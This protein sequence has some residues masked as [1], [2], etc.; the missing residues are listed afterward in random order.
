MDDVRRLQWG[1]WRA[2]NRL[3][4]IWSTEGVDRTLIVSRF[5]FCKTGWEVLLVKSFILNIVFLVDP[6]GPCEVNAEVSIIEASIQDPSE[7]RRAT[8]LYMRPSPS[9]SP[10]PR[11]SFFVLLCSLSQHP[12]SH[13]SPPHPYSSRC[14]R[15]STSTSLVRGITKSSYMDTTA[16]TLIRGRLSVSFIATGSFP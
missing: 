10:S 11:L 13:S 4:L 2:H 12:S 1:I 15:Y 6:P 14:I 7:A 5:C 3:A 8:P 9:P 16:S